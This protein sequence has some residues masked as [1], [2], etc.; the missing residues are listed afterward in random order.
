[1]KDL[2]D[3][4]CTDESAPMRTFALRALAAI[5][6]PDAVE[7]LIRGFEADYKNVQGFKVSRDY[8]YRREF[9]EK[10]LE[11]LK[12]ITGED[13]GVKTKEWRRWLD[14]HRGAI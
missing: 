11:A 1:M 14:A 3:V 10:I 7:G 13:F 2:T 6:T 5:R 12:E 4:L 8:D 9:R